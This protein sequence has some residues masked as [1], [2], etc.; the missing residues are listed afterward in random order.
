MR[1]VC[2]VRHRLFYKGVS[3]EATETN[4]RA[5]EKNN[6]ISDCIRVGCERFD[7]VSVGILPKCERSTRSGRTY[8]HG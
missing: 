4:P 5:W 7:G 1:R 8:C 6:D 3:Y 2:R